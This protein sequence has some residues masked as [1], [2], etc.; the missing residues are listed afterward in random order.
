MLAVTAVLEAR[1]AALETELADLRRTFD[2]ILGYFA[3]LG[4]GEA[5]SREA[6]RQQRHLS[7]VR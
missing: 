6:D 2:G 7:V 3:A 1:V 4:R 5:E